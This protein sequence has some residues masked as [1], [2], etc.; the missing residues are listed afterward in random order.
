MD[1]RLSEE[2]EI[3]RKSARDFLTQRCPLDALPETEFDAAAFDAGL[4][5]EMASL[6]WLGLALPE[7]MG[8]SGGSDVELELLCEELGRSLCPAPFLPIAVAARTALEHAGSSRARELI[9]ALAAGTSRPVLAVPDGAGRW[10]PEDTGVRLEGSSVTGRK[11]FVEAGTLADGLLVTATGPD[12]AC[13]LVLVD[14]RAPG[15]TVSPLTMMSG[16]QFAEVTFDRVH[17]EPLD[18]GWDAIDAAVVR[19]SVMHAAWC[20][21]AAARLLEDTVVYVSGRHQFG[22]PLGSFQAV[23]HRLADCDIATAEAA[24]LARQA[25]ELLAQDSSAARRM[26]STAF[27]RATDAFVTVARSCHQV[28]GGIGFCTEAH[29]HLFSR[30]AKVAQH[31]WGGTAHHLDVV[32]DEVRRL[33]LL[34]DRYEDALMRRGI[35]L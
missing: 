18:A 15:T 31:S 28:W 5:K 33:P 11:G 29:V 35:A 9:S 30:R 25:G 16:A 2:Q 20:A 4:W 17:A 14:P 32:A 3:L 10:G 26:S 12:G 34:R 8:G 21:G 23:Q 6:A 27:V 24:T 22:V 7:G 13:T 19:T 1:L